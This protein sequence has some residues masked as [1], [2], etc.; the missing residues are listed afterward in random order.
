MI[1]LAITAVIVQFAIPSYQMHIQKAKQ[2]E[3]QTHAIQE[4]INASLETPR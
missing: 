3:T 2:L 1:I 4:E